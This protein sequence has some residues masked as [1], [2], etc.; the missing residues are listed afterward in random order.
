MVTLIHNSH[1]QGEITSSHEYE[2]NTYIEDVTS[3]FNCLFLLSKNL[4]V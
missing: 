1:Y 3:H 4:K 2:N